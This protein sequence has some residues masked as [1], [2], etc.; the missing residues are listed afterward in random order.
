MALSATSSIK[1]LRATR[2]G[3]G[4]YQL[5]EMLEIPTLTS[6]I[7]DVSWAP[8]GIRPYDLIAAACDDGRVR[9]YEV[10]TPGSSDQSST[11]PGLGPEALM[12]QR[13]ASSTVARQTPS[14]IGA[15]LAGVSQPGSTRRAGGHVQHAWKEVAV[16]SHD[17]GAPVW[18]VRWTHD[19]SVL[20]STGDSGKLHL[21]KQDLSMRFVEFAETGLVTNKKTGAHEQ[22]RQDALGWTLIECQSDRSSRKFFRN[23]TMDG[24]GTKAVPGQLT[25]PTER[26]N[27]ERRVSTGAEE[28]DRDRPGTV[29]A[30][31]QSDSNHA[32][33]V[34]KVTTLPK[35]IYRV[36]RKQVGSA[37]IAPMP[38]S[39]AGVNRDATSSTKSPRPPLKK[40]RA[41]PLLSAHLAAEDVVLGYHA[42]PSVSSRS[43]RNN[44]DQ[45]IPRLKVKQSDESNMCEPRDE[46]Q[47]QCWLNDDSTAVSPPITSITSRLGIKYRRPKHLL[48]AWLRGQYASNLESR[49]VNT[50][51]DSHSSC[52]ATGIEIVEG[53]LRETRLPR[54]GE[55]P[56]S[57]VG[58]EMEGEKITATRHPL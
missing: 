53:R 52:G 31:V 30:V 48:P 6:A 49:Q 5:Y 1:I 22:W 14:G 9:L 13:H 36:P 45:S 10:T 58:V 44:S 17:D 46:K 2:P 32:P 19:G 11:A 40:R 29:T 23:D 21:W 47:T 41:R 8:G 26:Q 7:N 25:V 55:V 27:P 18:R 12:R 38:S 20:A 57:D 56:L 16:L 3:Y 35:E 28:F 37:T 15:G 24:D 51:R 43:Q 39:V 42:Y 34:P 4:N 33:L 50:D 54:L